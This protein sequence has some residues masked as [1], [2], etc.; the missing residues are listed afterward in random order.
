[1]RLLNAVAFFFAITSALFLYGLNYE[2]RRLEANVQ[3]MER[4]ADKARSDIAVL[5]AERSHLSRPERIDGLARQQGLAPPRPDQLPSVAEMPALA[6][7]LP[8]GR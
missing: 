6:A 7:T 1:M 2:T 4:A 3:A 5:K 8:E